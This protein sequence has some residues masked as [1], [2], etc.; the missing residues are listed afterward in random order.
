MSFSFFKKQESKTPN[1]KY[2]KTGLSR[3]KF[4]PNFRN[5]SECYVLPSSA[6][7]ISDENPNCTKAPEKDVTSTL[8]FELM[9]V[10]S[11]AAKCIIVLT[12]IFVSAIIYFCLAHFV[13]ELREKLPDL[14]R[15]VDGL[16][17]V[18]NALFSTIL[19]IF[20]L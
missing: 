12:K 13:P 10:S 18:L 9:G 3:A 8:N 4:S 17:S 6:Y 5:S 1:F 11:F 19:S 20:G 16:L 7:T 2:T 14:Y 15:V